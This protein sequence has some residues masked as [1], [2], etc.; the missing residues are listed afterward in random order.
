MNSI[1]CSMSVDKF[2]RY[3]KQKF[4]S[5]IL[6]KNVPR[7]VGIIVDNDSSLNVQNKRIKNLGIPRDEADAINKGYLQAEVNRIQDEIKSGLNT[8]ILN[9]RKDIEQ[10]QNTLFLVYS[11]INTNMKEM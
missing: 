7:I 2:G 5:S 1:N 3:S 8:E 4:S 11:N 6:K 10:L 9:I